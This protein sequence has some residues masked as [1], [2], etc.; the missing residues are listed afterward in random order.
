MRKRLGLFLK[1]PSI[2]ALVSMGV[3]SINYH[4]WSQMEMTWLLTNVQQITILQIHFNT[5]SLDFNNTFYLIVFHM[6]IP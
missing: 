1:Q 6:F 4:A 2:D 3:Y 5:D